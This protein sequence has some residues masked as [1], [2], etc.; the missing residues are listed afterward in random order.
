MKTLKK[1]STFEDLK[2]REQVTLDFKVRLKKHNDFER[3]INTIYSLKNN[4]K[5][6]YQSK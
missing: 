1:Y 6:N 2:S 5:L 3:I 4:N